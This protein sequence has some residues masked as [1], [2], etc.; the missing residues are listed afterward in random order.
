MDRRQ[1]AGYFGALGLGS[2]LLPDLLWAR[3]QAGEDITE[4]TIQCAEEI[5]GL[6]FEE[7][8][9]KAMVDGLKRQQ[10]QVETLR[11]IS[12]PNSVS[13]AVTF[14]PVLP[15][16]TIPAPVKRPMVR[17]RVPLMTRPGSLEDLAFRPVSELSE[18]VRRRTVK[19]TEL[20][21]MYVDRLKRYQPSL[22]T[23]ITFTEERALR[24]ARAADEEIAD[25][26]GDPSMAFHGAQKTS[27]LCAAILPRG[28]QDHS[29]SR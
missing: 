7:A 18:L 3:V 14:D 23:V 1:F 13:P 25:A 28:E 15:G 8:Q 11:R 17:S 20:T 24:Q 6:K 9:R 12:L 21:R 27:W 26:I 4:S 5:A 2:T 10:Q 22:K 19:S 16:T 29:V